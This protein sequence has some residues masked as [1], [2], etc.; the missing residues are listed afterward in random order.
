LLDLGMPE[1]D[2]YEVASR[3]RERREFDDVLLIAL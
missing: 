2:G 3:I 1:M